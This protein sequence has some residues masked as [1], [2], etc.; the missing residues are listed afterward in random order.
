VGSPCEG[1]NRSGSC[2]GAIRGCVAVQKQ[3]LKA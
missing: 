2:R 1:G 3:P